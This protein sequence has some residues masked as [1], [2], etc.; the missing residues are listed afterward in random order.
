MLTNNVREWEPLWRAMLPVDEIFELVVDS[1]FVGCASPTREIYELTLERLGVPR[2]GVPVRRRHRGQLRRARAALGMHAVVFRDNAQAIAE[3]RSAL[4]RL[5]CRS[6]PVPDVE[7]DA[8][9]RELHQARSARAGQ[10]ELERVLLGDAGVERLLAAEA[11]GE[12]QRLAAVLAERGE[13]AHQEVAVGDRLADLE[14]AVPG[15]EH[16]EVVLV[17]LGDRL[18]VVDSSSSSGISSTQARTASPSSCR[19]AS[20]PTESAIARI[21]SCGR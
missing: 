5:S 4:A 14:R 16:R 12:L 17:E 13:G 15:G 7:L 19:R 18:R 1:G 6:R 3:I 11:G 8:S 2:R 21:A 9:T 20:R 10:D